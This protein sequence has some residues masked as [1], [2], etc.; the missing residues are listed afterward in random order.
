MQTI[1]TSL[2]ADNH[3]NTPSLNFLQ[4]GCSSCRQTNSVKALKA[5]PREQ[6]KCIYRHDAVASTERTLSAPLSGRGHSL[7]VDAGVTL[8]ARRIADG[9]QRSEA[10]TRAHHGCLATAAAADA[11]GIQ[12]GPC[13]SQSPTEL[14]TGEPRRTGCRAC[15][16]RCPLFPDM[17]G[18][19]QF[20]FGG[21]PA[22]QRAKLF[23][24]T[25]C[26]CK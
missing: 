6:W 26:V 25:V 20:K 4:A 19:T 18:H 5:E 23:S 2:L 8:A 10:R 12:S 14:T 9:C 1:C 17:L 16:D 24:V 7:G 3:T 22:E 11:S 13:N 15:C 21:K